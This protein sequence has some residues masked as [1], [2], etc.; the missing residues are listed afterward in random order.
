MHVGKTDIGLM[1]DFNVTLTFVLSLS[2]FYQVN[3]CQNERL[4][5]VLT[6]LVTLAP[7]DDYG[8]RMI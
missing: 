7:V 3:C 5:D 1:Q 8:I 4:K 2:R 6:D